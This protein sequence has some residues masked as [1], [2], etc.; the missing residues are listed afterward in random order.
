MLVHR[1]RHLQP[2]ILEQTGSALWVSATRQ[3]VGLQ[4]FLLLSR[5]PGRGEVDA[6]RDH[7]LVHVLTEEAQ[8]TLQ[9]LF[10]SAIYLLENSCSALKGIW[11]QRRAKP[12]LLVQPLQQWPNPDLLPATQFEG[13]APKRRTFSPKKVFTEPAVAKRLEA[14]A[15]N[16]DRRARWAAL[17]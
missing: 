15:L 3:K 9:G 12:E 5:E 13:Y 17:D 2:W 8:V 1:G 7:D 11:A 16:D 6:L 4:A 10:N 14:A